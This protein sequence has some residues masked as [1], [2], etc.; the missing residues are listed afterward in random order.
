MFTPSIENVCTSTVEEYF[1]KSLF[2]PYLESII[3][4]LESRFSAECKQSFS[5]FSL[6]PK[7]MIEMS[8]QEYIKH[9]ENVK[10]RT[11]CTILK[12]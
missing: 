9:V 7:D 6:Y 11:R 5:L 12:L 2:V 1:R 8:E 4:S 10:T 3:S